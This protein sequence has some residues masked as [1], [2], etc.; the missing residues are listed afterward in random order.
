MTEYNVKEVPH[1]NESTENY[2]LNL[3]HPSVHYGVV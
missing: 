1:D 3:Y 2:Q